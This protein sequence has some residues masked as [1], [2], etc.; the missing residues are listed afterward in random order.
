MKLLSTPK[1]RALGFQ[2]SCQRS[3]YLAL[4]L[5]GGTNPSTAKTLVPG[6]TANPR[7]IPPIVGVVAVTSPAVTPDPKF[8]GSVKITDMPT[9]IKVEANL[10]YTPA[11]ISKGKA[12]SPELIDLCT[13][14]ALDLGD[15]LGA[16]ASATPGTE[17]LA[18]ITTVEQLLYRESLAALAELNAVTISGLPAS[19]IEKGLYQPAAVV[20]PISV[21][22]VLLH[23]PKQSGSNTYLG[24]V[25]AVDDNSGGN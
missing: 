20:P 19:S 6:V 25:G 3:L 21:I 5:F 7:A 15:W 16:V 9:Y 24:S 8:V 11:A 2:N 12:L 18:G 14:A 1:F 10:P 4:Q 17:N 13:P 22:K 23:L